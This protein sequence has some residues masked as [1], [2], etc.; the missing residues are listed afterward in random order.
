M[1]TT[2]DILV[3]LSW[4]TALL[5]NVIID[6]PSNAGTIMLIIMPILSMISLILSKTYFVNKLIISIGIALMISA[7]SGFSWINLILL[8]SIISY[9][10]SLIEELKIR[11]PF[12]NR[13]IKENKE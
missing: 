13:E 8:F 2:I 5:I 1:K 6:Q 3:Y 9:F 11:I 10:I 7:I 12:M 4:I